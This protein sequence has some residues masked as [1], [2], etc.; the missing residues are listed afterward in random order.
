MLLTPEIAGLAKGLVASHRPFDNPPK[1][2]NKAG[3]KIER[4]GHLTIHD[5]S[6]VRRKNNTFEK[7][8]TAR[9]PTSCTLLTGLLFCFCLVFLGLCY[10]S[11]VWELRL[12]LNKQVNCKKHMKEHLMEYGIAWFVPKLRSKKRLQNKNLGLRFVSFLCLCLGKR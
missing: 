1:S 11:W 2:S 6:S 4:G 8:K 5:T 7:S 3:R 12:N 10:D 9:T